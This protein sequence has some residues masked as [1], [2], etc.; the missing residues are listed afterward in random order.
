MNYQEQAEPNYNFLYKSIQQSYLYFQYSSYVL[1]TF[2]K[3]SPNQL[4]L[5]NNPSSGNS[6][7]YLGHFPQ[8]SESKTF[9]NKPSGQPKKDLLAI[10]HKSY[11]QSCNSLY[12]PLNHN[13]DL[14][15]TFLVQ[16][17]VFQ[18]VLLS[19]LTLISK[20]QSSSGWQFQIPHQKSLYKSL[21]F[22]ERLL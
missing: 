19:L 14:L 21:N 9:F 5:S 17:K 11:T 8:F 22:K 10:C 2:S 15:N 18:Q 3:A 4:F 7:N 16:L 20:L 1:A 13:D 6:Q 12:Q